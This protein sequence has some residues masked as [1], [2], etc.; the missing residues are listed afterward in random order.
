MLLKLS[1]VA[2]P[3][4]VI[5]DSI[6]VF[7]FPVQ[8]SA[9]DFF[10]EIDRFEDGAVGMP[11]PAD[12]IDFAGARGIDEFGKGLHQIETMNV[13]AYL[14]ALVTENSIRAPSNGADHQVR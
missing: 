1:D 7:V 6:F 9:A 14:L 8:F 13:V 4:D 11:A 12:V 10:A 3:P 2:D 5:A